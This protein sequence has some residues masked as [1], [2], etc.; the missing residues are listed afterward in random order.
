M[1]PLE[2]ETVSVEEAHRSL[3]GDRAKAG[4]SDGTDK[5]TPT[6]KEALLEVTQV[7]LASLPQE[8][9]PLE[10]ARQFPRISNRL[11]FLWRNA[12][13]CEQYLDD[14][15]VDRRGTRKGFP[16]EITRELEALREYYALL[17]PGIHSKW[18]LVEERTR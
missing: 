16:E 14:L 8:V 12:A 13:R 15:L 9:R 6:L 7:W 5:R 3:E 4:A 17:H 2:F 10:L 1:K 11:R 18:D